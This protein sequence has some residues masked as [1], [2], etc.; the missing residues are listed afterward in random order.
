MRSTIC[1]RGESCEVSIFFFPLRIVIRRKLSATVSGI[2]AL[3]YRSR[4][5]PGKLGTELT[6]SIRKPK[7]KPQRNQST[8]EKKQTVFQRWL[9]D[10]MAINEQ[11]ESR[12]CTVLC[13]SRIF[14]IAL[15]RTA[16]FLYL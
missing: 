15:R 5:S 1:E 13:Q 11:S 4:D 12:D 2:C 3:S 6:S 10:S 8:E 9:H 7:S 16:Y 14:S